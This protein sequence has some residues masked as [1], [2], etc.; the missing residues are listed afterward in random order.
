MSLKEILEENSQLTLEALQR[1]QR[2]YDKK[3]VAGEFSG[4]DKVRHTYAHLG[5]LL[6]RLAQ[7]VQAIEDGNILESTDALKEKVIPDLLVYSVWL[8]EELGVSIEE[9][10]LRRFV[11]NIQRLHK[12]KISPEELK[13]LER[14][15]NERFEE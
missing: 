10:Y 2:E 7:Y 13:G 12:D 15:V 1:L 3:F 9:A 4:F 11:G 8:A 14:H 5:K 6:G